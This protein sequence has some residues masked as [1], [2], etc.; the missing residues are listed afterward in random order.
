MNVIAECEARSSVISSIYAMRYSGATLRQIA[1]RIGK[2]KERVRQILLHNYGST[3]HKLLSTRQLCGLSGVSVKRLT[4]LHRD[5][6]IMPVKEWDTSNG[7]TGCF[8]SL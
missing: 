1:D 5:G 3:R 6:V 2:T 4:R 7:Q 8:C